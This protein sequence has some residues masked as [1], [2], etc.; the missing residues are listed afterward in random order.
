MS[1]F[2][3]QRGTATIATGDTS[4][5]ITA[6]TDYT[7]PSSTTAAFARI[8]GVAFVGSGRQDSDF[9][10][11]P[12]IETTNITGTI[13]TSLTIAR[14]TGT[15]G[16]IDIS[17]EIIEYT[18]AASGDNEFLVRSAETVNFSGSDTTKDSATI[19]GVVTDA[20]VVVFITG[21]NVGGGG[22]R[23]ETEEFQL[24]SEYVSA[25]NVARLTRGTNVD[26]AA[27]PTIAVVEF[28]G[29]NW[30]AQRIVHNYSSSATNETESITTIGSLSKA[31]LH[32]QS[33]ISQVNAGSDGLGQIAWI[34]STSQLTFYRQDIGSG[35]VGVAWVIENTQATGTVMNVAQYSGTR[36]NGVGSDPDVFTQS[37]TA[38]SALA[39]SSIMG[40]GAWNT[41]D[42][43]DVHR[44]M[45]NFELTAVDT[46]TLTRGRNTSDRNWR[47]QV[48]EWPSAGGGGGGGTFKPY[49]ALN[50]SSII[51]S[52][53]S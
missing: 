42:N 18:G 34:S 27:D 37:V 29:S 50:R 32:H 31:F 12:H 33:R 11:N 22:S 26:R 21:V 13:T 1:D 30:S 47:Y 40:E 9:F 36:A 35:S 49:W 10:G 48:V 25:S 41:G 51:N 2:A 39:Q 28:T 6:G 15:G 17:W 5:T 19:S 3:I 23:R 45:L 14:I 24:T 4:I 7:A 53:I 44:G 16:P 46:V 43:A 8:V 52:G 38:V 20:D